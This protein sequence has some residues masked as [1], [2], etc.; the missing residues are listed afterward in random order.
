MGNVLNS[1]ITDFSFMLEKWRC[2]LQWVPWVG[3]G[4]W[5]ESIHVHHGPG[6]LAEHED[7]RKPNPNYQGQELREDQKVSSVCK[8][9]ACTNP[10]HR[11]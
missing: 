10:A 4:V 6:W 9:S 2:D 7:K 5:R 8:S 1:V 11:E 3:I